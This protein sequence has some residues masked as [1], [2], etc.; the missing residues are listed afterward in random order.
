MVIVGNK[1]DR[2]SERQV[3][4]TE[5]S[6]FASGFCCNEMSARTNANVNETFIQL[7]TVASLPAK[8]CPSLHRQLQATSSVTERP[9]IFRR[10]TDNSACGALIPNVLRP[11]VQTELLQQQ[12]RLNCADVERPQ[13]TRVVIAKCCK[14]ELL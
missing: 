10:R 7:L 9:S 8:M 12:R 2:D 3:G 1:S 5:L 14:C 11:D 13:P 6:E 4:Q